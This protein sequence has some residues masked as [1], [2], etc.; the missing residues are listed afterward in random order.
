MH[1]L[2]IKSEKDAGQIDEFIKNGSDVFILVY[3]EG[4]GPCN[5]SRPQW[6]KLESALKDQYANND[7][8]VVVDVNKN[9]LSSIKH[10]GNVDG[11]PTIKYIGNHGKIVES[12]EKSSISKKNRSASSF[13]VWIESKINNVIS[14]TPTSSP[15]HVYSRLAKTEK[16]VHRAHRNNK[17]QHR[18]NNN[19]NKNNT[20]HKKPKRHRGGKWS[21]KYKKSIDCNKPKGFSQKQHCK[22]GRK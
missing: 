16:Q 15:Q 19:N 5:A 8:L 21:M 11:Y 13:I 22:Y 12:Y 1:I 6:A 17:T 20:K 14:T 4:C 10:I 3:M 7:K 18:K 2:H 9:F